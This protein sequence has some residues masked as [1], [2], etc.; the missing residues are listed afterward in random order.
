MDAPF[1][2]IFSGMFA[3]IPGI[4]FAIG[5]SE[6]LEQVNIYSHATT[7]Q[8]VIVAPDE[9]VVYAPG[10]TPPPPRPFSEIDPRVRF[11]YTAEGKDRFAEQD[12][13]FLQTSGKL[14][15]FS[16]GDAVTVHYNAQ[17]PGTAWLHA[18]IDA[19]PFMMM[20]F[21]T[22]FWAA[23]VGV[24]FATGPIKSARPATPVGDGWHQ[25]PVL[26]TRADKLLNAWIFLVVASIPGT[27]IYLHTRIAPPWASFEMGIATTLYLLFVCAI[28]AHVFYRAS[29][30][31]AGREAVVL[32]NTPA[33]T[34]GQPLMVRVEHDLRRAVPAATLEVGLHC[35][36][37]DKTSGGG[38]T[39]Y[40]TDNVHDSWQLSRDVSSLAMGQP[41][42]CDGELEFPPDARPS[43]P[44][45][46]RS[47]PRHTWT[48]QVRTR[49]PG[50]DYN[51]KFPLQ[52][53]AG[54]MPR[55]RMMPHVETTGPALSAD[56]AHALDLEHD[57][58]RIVAD[59]QDDYHAADA[60]DPNADHDN[61]PDT[62]PDDN[63][64]SNPN[65][66]PNADDTPHAQ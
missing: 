51:A 34:I 60:Y 55:P 58:H 57:T 23:A 35:R 42:V 29:A 38:K 32:I 9:G 43:N 63:P 10:V 59:V 54:S 66:D 46:D 20:L 30:L 17:R 16:L 65:A 1:R 45:G 4:F 15:R 31:R 48:V 2:W 18:D 50:A 11:R 22:P 27:A 25:L 61:N 47:Y 56:E 41:A 39:Q 6:A 36:R 49:L 26:S 13:F 33:A 53:L 24:F 37:D 8:G 14:P 19:M 5:L 64:Y 12:I 7:T 62:S 21:V 28:I 52:V 44:E 40:S 3:L